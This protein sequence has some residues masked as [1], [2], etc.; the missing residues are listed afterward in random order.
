MTATTD[1]EKI[2][3]AGHR[4]A[5]AEAGYDFTPRFD[6]RCSDFI[7]VDLNSN[8]YLYEIT[9]SDFATILNNGERELWS[10]R[11]IVRTKLINDLLW[12][13]PRG[14]YLDYDMK[15]ER[16]SEVTAVTTFQPLWVGCA[17]G[18]QAKRVRENLKL[19]EYAYGIVPCEAGVHNFVYQW[20]YPNAWPPHALIVSEALAKYNYKE[21]AERIRSKYVNT[22]YEVFKSTGTLW[23]KYNAVEGN[24]KVKEEYKTPSMIGW[25]A[26][27]YAH[28]RIVNKTRL[29]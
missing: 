9:M 16:Q 23:E 18:E 3:I 29:R 22:V 12:N 21:D 4:L 15:N 13:E 11:A 2:S 7:P 27:I 14:L 24:A 8:L 17:S 26:G 5:E 20:D 1:K 6:G 28:M 25:N 10:E 19:Y